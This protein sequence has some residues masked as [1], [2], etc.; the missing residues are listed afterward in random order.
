MNTPVKSQIAATL[1]ILITVTSI[2]QEI[3]F[4][5]NLLV[6]YFLSLID[7][8]IIMLIFRFCI[9]DSYFCN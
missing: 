9:F 3:H 2:D 1:L 6:H 8:D 7:T 4:W 5:E